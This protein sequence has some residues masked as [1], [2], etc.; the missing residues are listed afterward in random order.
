MCLHERPIRFESEGYGIRE[1][2]A[3]DDTAKPGMLDENYEA[4]LHEDEM[5]K[6]S[7]R[8]YLYRAILA[9]GT[10]VVKD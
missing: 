9:V 2:G 7:K 6:K 5:K 4:F 3:D 8:Y 1:D 10:Y